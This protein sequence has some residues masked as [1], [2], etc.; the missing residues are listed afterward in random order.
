M[1]PKNKKRTGQYDFIR[2]DFSPEDANEIIRHLFLKKISFHEL[3]SF[4]SQ[5][6]W[7]TTDQD[8]LNRITDLRNCMIAIEENIQIARESGKKVRLSSII[9]IDIV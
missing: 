6:R 8:S 4:S 5:I 3:K 9:Y 1:T 2:G 7:G